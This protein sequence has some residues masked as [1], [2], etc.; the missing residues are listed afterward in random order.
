MKSFVQFLQEAAKT[1]AAT[2][3]QQ[4]GL[5]GDG[6]GGWY[7]RQGK[8]V[9]KTVDGK[10]KFSGGRNS[11]TDDAPSQGKP[12][13]PA[14]PT[15]KKTAAA[16]A[17]AATGSAK[18]SGEDENTKKSDSKETDQV[19]IPDT[20]PSQYDGVV[21]VFGRFNPPTTGHQKLLQRAKSEASRKN[22]ALKVYPSR[23]QDKKKN[24][25]EPGTKIEYMKKMFDDVADD[26]IDDPE[27]KT[28]F[29]V[30]VAANELGFSRLTIMVGQDRLSEFQSLAH[31]YNG[32]L[33][34]FEEIEVV[35]AGTRDADAEGLE[36]MSASKMRKAAADGDFKA[37]VKGIPNLGNMEKKELFNNIRKSMGSEAKSESY[38][39]EIAPKLDE[40]NLRETYRRGDLF[41]IGALVENLNT[42]ETGRITRRGTNHVICMTPEGTMFKSWLRDL[43]EAYE[44]GTDD[45]REY[46]QSMSA[47]QPVRKFG[48]PKKRIKPTILPLKPNDPKKHK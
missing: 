11:K 33:Y 45:Y 20:D 12:Q 24:P 47:G 16:P 27:A 26:I 1:S 5:V 41:P 35:S 38:V 44:I 13:K 4:R 14:E 39:W 43:A 34:E 25:L 8:F 37:F 9:A 19:E 17:P 10:L 29:D 2:Q 30:M 3:A 32:D 18:S 46:V 28:I 23:T 15:S 42:G 22:F 6:H 31:K 21:V 48:E 40:Y 36:G 7:D